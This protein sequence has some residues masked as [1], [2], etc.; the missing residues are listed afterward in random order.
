MHP[1]FNWIAPFHGITWALDI[2][3]AT[4]ITTAAAAVIVNHVIPKEVVLAADTTG[5]TPGGDLVPMTHHN[6][7]HPD[8][9]TVDHNPAKGIDLTTEAGLD[10]QEDVI[11]VN[12]ILQIINIPGMLQSLW[13]GSNVEQVKALIPSHEPITDQVAKIVCS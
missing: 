12:P 2:I 5:A 10:P 6:H 1:A 13:T 3:A 8:D 7:D 9:T 4:A 11:A